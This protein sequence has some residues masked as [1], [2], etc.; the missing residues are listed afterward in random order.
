MQVLDPLQFSARGMDPALMM[1]TY[2]DRLTF[3]GGIDIQQVVPRLATE[4]M[5]GE[6]R[7]VV[8]MMSQRRGYI[9]AGTHCFQAD[10][11]P[12][13]IVA[14]FDFAHEYRGENSP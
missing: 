8:D 1:K 12:E 4:E 3:H 10:A 9:F 7:R 5:L 11:S 14:L 6:A 13:K 2:G